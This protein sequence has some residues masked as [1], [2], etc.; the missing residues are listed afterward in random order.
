MFKL[1]LDKE[2]REIIGTTKFAVTF[3][4]C[5][6]LI[7]LA[8]Y[9][10]ARNYQVSRSEFEAAQVANLKQME[11]LTDWRQIEHRIFL[12]PQPLASL[13]SGV[14][15]DIGRTVSVQSR[16]ELKSSGSR[17]NEDPIYAV[18]RFLD[19]EF[20]FTIVLSLFAI[21]F[22]FDAVNGEKQR[23]T[24]RLSFANAIP[25]D[26]YILGKVVGSFIALVVPLLI[27]I[28]LG[29][30][31]LPVLGIPMD[32]NSW[33]RL[34]MIILAGILYFGVFL[35]LSVFVSSLTQKSSSSFLV[36]LVVWIVMVLIIPRTSVLISGRAVDVPSIDQVDYAKG[37][38]SRQIFAEQ[39]KEMNE[40]IQDNPMTDD[41]LAFMTKMNDFS[42]E[43]GTIREQ[44]M[45]IFTQQLNEDRRNKSETRQRLA[46]SLARISPTASFSLAAADLASTSLDLRTSYLESANEYRAQYAEFM[47]EQGVDDS[48]FRISFG[49]RNDEE[50][51]PP[52]IETR[53][54]PVFEYSPP[55]AGEAISESLPDLGLLML[56]N[57][58]FFAGSFVAFLRYDVR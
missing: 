25:R 21:L 24:L 54:L 23:G 9:V 28:L 20:I 27:P 47:V 42:K 50:E 10:G 39:M 37:K 56:F 16:G 57:I 32:S 8:F 31:L 46:L 58:V 45:N 30:L 43:Q 36:L 4:V 53:E 49:H 2:L 12:P 34:T 35:T 52:P 6:I 5:A 15:N 38:F 1:I 51:P 55:S 40:F 29:C 7:L 11:G 33:I 3:G 13:V 26:Q 48:G 41:H 44:K 18:F 22:G 17:F 19:L 14:S